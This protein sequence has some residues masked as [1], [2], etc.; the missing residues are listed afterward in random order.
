MVVGAQKPYG[1]GPI[2]NICSNGGHGDRIED[3]G[4]CRSIEQTDISAV[5]VKHA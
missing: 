1:S 3:A 4:S 5:L 2:A